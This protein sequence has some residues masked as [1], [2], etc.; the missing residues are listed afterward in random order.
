MYNF[1]I[2]H[3]RRHL[4]TVVASVLA[5]A[6]LALAFR[7]SERPLSR[8][9]VGL[10]ALAVA[11]N[12]GAVG[13]KLLT[14]V[15]WVVGR[16]KYDVLSAALA[17]DEPRRVLDVGSGTGRSIV[18]VAPYLPDHSEVTALDVF[19][20]RIVLGNTPQRAGSNLAKAGVDGDVLIGDAARM[21]VSDDS[22]DLVVISRLLHDV[23][24]RTA[25]RTLAEARRVLEPGG[26][27]GVL[28][29]PIVPGET[30]PERYWRDLVSEAGFTVDTVRRPAW[31]DD[32]DYVVLAATPSEC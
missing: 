20:D 23:P 2:Y 29:L 24:E 5:L 1:G 27:L 10:G 18:G 6:A 26:Q 31:K 13:R 8:L 11:A 4:R 3:W 7:R 21:P 22:H 30:D 25:R 17:L 28:E 9:A 19:D 15:P 32:R 14:P 12:L 16:Q